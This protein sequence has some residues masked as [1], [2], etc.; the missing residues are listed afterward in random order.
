MIDDTAYMIPS[1]NV[2][3]RRIHAISHFGLWDSSLA[4]GSS[5]QAGECKSVNLTIQKGSKWLHTVVKICEIAHFKDEIF[6]KSQINFHSQ[7]PKIFKI[8]EHRIIPSNWVISRQEV[9]CSM[10]DYGDEQTIPLS[11]IRPLVSQFATIPI[12]ACKAALEGLSTCTR[13]SVYRSL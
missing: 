7:T 12:Q 8:G 1:I 3:D 11:N 4:P 5:S 9:Y 6:K 10:V 13:H 2:Y